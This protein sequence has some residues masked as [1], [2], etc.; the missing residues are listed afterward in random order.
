MIMLF[1]RRCAA[2]IIYPG[3][4]AASIFE[5]NIKSTFYRE[6]LKWDLVIEQECRGHKCINMIKSWTRNE[7]SI[8]NSGKSTELGPETLGRRHPRSQIFDCAQ[9]RCEDVITGNYHHCWN[10]QTRCWW[11]HFRIFE[12]LYIFFSMLTF[13]LFL[14]KMYN[15]R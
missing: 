3:D 9:L 8:I 1:F 7:N 2:L 10:Y 15:Y 12:S 4:T 6:I 13:Y 11:W 14:R 5:Q